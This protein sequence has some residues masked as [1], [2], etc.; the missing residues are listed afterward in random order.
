MRPLFCS[1]AP[2]RTSV[3]LTLAVLPLVTAC[4][5]AEE[6]PPGISLEQF[7]QEFQGATCEHLVA[8]NWM[9]D[10]KTCA[11]S[12]GV[13][14]GIAQAVTAANSG[15]LTYDPAAAR[16]CVDALRAA[17]CNGDLLI[18]RSV[19]ESCDPVFGGRKGEGESCYHPAECQ[20]LNASCEGACTDSCCIGTCRLEAGFAAIGESCTML[21]CKSDAY[22]SPG[23]MNSCVAKVGP[24][25]SCADAPD[26]CPFGYA[27][28]PGTLTCFKQAESGAACNPDLAANGC[29]AIGEYCDADKRQ[30]QP[31]PGIGDAC[32]A[33]AYRSNI[34]AYGF[35]RCDQ[36]SATCVAQPTEGEPCP[37]NYCVGMMLGS[38][39][40][41]AVICSAP[42]GSGTCVEAP[43]L[44]T[45]VEP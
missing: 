40:T 19:R 13:E 3:A 32:E 12:I 20:G 34:C 16:T 24:G 21:P 30:C 31:L 4:G 10:L 7:T 14:Q 38:G 22:C 9:P 44:P 8:C 18:P 23:A 43:A 28:D 41:E 6:G 36:A 45:C 26:A 39:I 11:A 1:L 37:G 2:V 5:D 29:F 33:N 25:E 17:S 42:D 35:A 15:V 27:C